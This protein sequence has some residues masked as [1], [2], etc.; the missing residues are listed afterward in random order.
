MTKVNTIAKKLEYK[1]YIQKTVYNGIDISL[2]V[3][4]F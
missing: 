3:P 4:K 2:L 1:S